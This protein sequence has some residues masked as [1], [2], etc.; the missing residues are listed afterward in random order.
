MT[1]PFCRHRPVVT[2]LAVVR[3]IVVVRAIF[4]IILIFM[5]YTH[6]HG[7][8]AAETARLG[9]QCGT[10]GMLYYY[11]LGKSTVW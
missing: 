3:L 10:V 7:S 11:L 1:R 4:I 8:L 9:V 5:R 6:Y 2:I